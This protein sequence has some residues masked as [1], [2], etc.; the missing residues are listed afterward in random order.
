MKQNRNRNQKYIEN[1]FDFCFSPI[2]RYVWVYMWK[3]WEMYAVKSFLEQTNKNEMKKENMVNKQ[4][5]PIFKV[6]VNKHNNSVYLR[7]G[8]SNHLPKSDYKPS[9]LVISIFPPCNLYVWDGPLLFFLLLFIFL[10]IF[11]FPIA[12]QTKYFTQ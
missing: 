8:V 12:L 10:F 7:F 6:F 2:R 4:M 11:V 9:T 5:K 3:C 1:F